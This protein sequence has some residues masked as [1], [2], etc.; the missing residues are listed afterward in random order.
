MA[1]VLLMCWFDVCI[2]LISGGK[3]V[4]EGISSEE[5]AA[6]DRRGRRSAGSSGRGADCGV[7][8]EERQKPR[9]KQLRW[10][11]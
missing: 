5:S 7:G 4:R 9:G 10:P 8:Q 1:A 3:G 2:A 11:L 6:E